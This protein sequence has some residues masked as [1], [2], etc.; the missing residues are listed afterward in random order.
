MKKFTT[1]IITSVLATTLILTL[2]SCLPNDYADINDTPD[3]NLPAPATR[4][5]LYSLSDVI[6]RDMTRADV[7]KKLGTGEE[8]RDDYGD[9]K[10]I[11]YYNEE[12]SAGVSVI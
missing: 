6:E 7:E 3:E 4:E 2:C 8:K 10:Y 5:E 9:V 11:N 12:K 1:R